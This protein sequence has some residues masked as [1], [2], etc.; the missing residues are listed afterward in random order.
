MDLPAP[1]GPVRN[2][3]S[4]GRDPERDVHQG[5][6]E[7]PVLLRDA[8]ELDHSAASSA[9]VRASRTAAGSAR[10][11]VFFITWPT[12]QPKVCVLPER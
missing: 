12:N 3:N 1:E 9:R 8:V 2:T 6:A 10:P 7:R 4:P 11:P 5:V